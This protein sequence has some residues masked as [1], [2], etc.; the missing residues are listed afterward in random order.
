[1]SG[2]LEMP[3]A[4]E[5]LEYLIR[6]PQANDTLEGIVE[7]W[8]RE[9]QIR[10]SVADAKSALAEFVE[11]NFVL[12]RRGTDGR[13]HYRMN[14]YKQTEI[15]KRLRLRASGCTT[16]RRGRKADANY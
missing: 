5:I 6:N 16:D 4:P 3:L 7:W 8:L 12:A 14:P 15:G 11:Q 1:M 2:I 10:H 9:H 13:T